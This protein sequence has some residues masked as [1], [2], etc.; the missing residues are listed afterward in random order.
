MEELAECLQGVLGQ[1]LL[2]LVEAF[3]SFRV[4]DRIDYT[5]TCGRSAWWRACVVGVDF[6]AELVLLHWL[7]YPAARDSWISTAHDAQHFELFFASFC[8]GWRSLRPGQLIRLLRPASPFSWEKVQ[9]VRMEGD[10]SENLHLVVESGCLEFKIRATDEVA[11]Y[12]L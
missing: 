8:S 10:T 7:G 5:F 9:L 3:W 12:F 2:G 1:D 6:S 4:G 11:L